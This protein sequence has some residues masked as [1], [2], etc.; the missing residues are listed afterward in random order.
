[1]GFTT[2]TCAAAAAKA[3]VKMLFSGREIK[4]V[5]ITLPINEKVELD[6]VDFRMNDE[7]VSCCIKKDAGDDPDVTDGAKIC[8]KAKKSGFNGIKI[9]GG[10]GVGRV[11]KKGLPV[12]VG[13]C[14]I[15]PVPREMIVKGV[16]EVLPK[17]EGVEIEIFVPGGK[18]LAK[19]TMNEKL[20]IIGGISILGTTGIVEPKS[21]DA[22]KN[23]LTLQ[24]DVANSAGI[25]EVVL[26]PG[27]FGEKRAMRKGIP[28]DAI[29]QT[30]NFIGFM[31]K[32]CVRKGMKKGLLFG[33]IGKLVK[34]SAGI[35]DTHSSVADARMETMAA[36]ASLCGASRDIVN[37]ILNS[38]TTETALDILKQ[39][40]L[41]QVFDIL[42]ERA[43]L[44]AMDYVD[45]EMKIGTIMISKEGIVVGSDKNAGRSKWAKYLLWE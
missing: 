7:E 15:N 37:D 14:A 29:V 4:K 45:G 39:N 8:A 35:F 5:E 36:Y 34:V 31:L 41:T 20:G 42:A 6:I 17:N 18:E 43:S 33:H 13:E 2:G 1:M 19:K 40:G 16:R 32:E 10:D 30:G 12:K 9:K 23:S 25:K 11:T 24:I 38:N 22:F 44:R 26:T 27:R 28:E 3:A 21:L